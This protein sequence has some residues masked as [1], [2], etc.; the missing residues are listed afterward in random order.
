MIVA[1]TIQ[2]VAE[3]LLFA[4]KA[5]ADPA[6]VRE[7]LMGGFASSRILEVHGQRM[8]K[9]NFEPGFRID[10]HRKDL[11]LALAGARALSLSLPATRDRQPAAARLRGQGR[12]CFGP[13]GDGQGAG[14]A[15]QSRDPPHQRGE[16][17]APLRRSAQAGR[18]GG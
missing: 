8:I 18:R 17:G 4:A 5:G 2:A 9:R 10:L 12:G 11:S 7:A 1:I 3:A 13:L 15:G 6:K 16:R 14:A